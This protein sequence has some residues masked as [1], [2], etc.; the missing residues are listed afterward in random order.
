LAVLRGLHDDFKQ[1][2]DRTTEIMR[3]EH[4]KRTNEDLQNLIEAAQKRRDDNRR[5]MLESLGMA[6]PAPPPPPVLARPQCGIRRVCAP[7]SESNFMCP[8]CKRHQCIG[9]STGIEVDEA[10]DQQSI[11]CGYIN[12][13]TGDRCRGVIYHASK[14]PASEVPMEELYSRL[15]PDTPINTQP[16]DLT[17][18]LDHNM[19]HAPEE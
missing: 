14:S 7:G 16:M 11:G 3:A 8:V 9:C 2:I 12:V 17:Q 19:F 1:R 5:A 10:T 4:P 6:T 13:N 15:V 18:V